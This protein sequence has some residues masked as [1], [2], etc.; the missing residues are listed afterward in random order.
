MAIFTYTPAKLAVFAYCGRGVIVKVRSSSSGLIPYNGK[1]S[2][3]ARCRKRETLLGGGFTTTPT[4][5]P[6]NSSGPD[7]SYSGS[8]RSGAR[9]WTARAKNY[10]SASGKV[11]AFAY[12]MP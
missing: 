7:L 2:A 9:S 4:P 1:G 6:L 8:Y 3:T 5:D 12:C 11:T 10:S